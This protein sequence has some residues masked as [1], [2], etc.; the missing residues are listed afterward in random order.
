MGQIVIV[1]PQ[2]LLLLPFESPRVLRMKYGVHTE[3]SIPISIYNIHWSIP[4]K[5]HFS[6]VVPIARIN[7]L[8]T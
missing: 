3:Y 7:A 4:L 5:T 8:P 2:T 1:G 6:F